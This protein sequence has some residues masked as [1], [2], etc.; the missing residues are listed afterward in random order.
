MSPVTIQQPRTNLSRLI[1]KV[2]AGE[3]IVIERG[4]R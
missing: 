1:Q 2:S 4:S 3:E